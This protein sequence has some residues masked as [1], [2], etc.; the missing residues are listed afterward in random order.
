MM[1]HFLTKYSLAL[2]GA[3][4]IFLALTLFTLFIIALYSKNYLSN[5]TGKYRYW[6]LSS[7]FS[8][9]MII[10]CLAK[11][12]ETFFVGWEIV[13]LASFFLIGFYQTHARSLE[14]SLIAL[15]NYKICDVF[16]VLAI[17][18]MELNQ[19]VWAGACLIISTLAKSAQFPFSSWLYRALEGPT[20]SSTVFYGGLSLHLGPFLLIQ[21]SHLWDQS[22]ELRLLM[23]GLGLISAIYGFLVG[24]TRSD[25][26]TS[27]AF[28]SISQVGLIYMELALGWYQF[29]LWHIVGHNILRT[30]N[31]LR[32]TSFFDDF[33][34]E[35]HRSTS[36]LSLIFFKMLPDKLY[37]HALNGFY[38][39]RLFIALRNACLFFFLG[40]SFVFAAKHLW[41][42]TFHTD[43]LLL[44]IGTFLAVI[45]FV[46]PH[47]KLI[48]QSLSLIASQI[49]LLTSIFLFYIDFL[50]KVYILSSLIFLGGTLWALAPALKQWAKEK[51]HSGDPFT[52]PSQLTPL[53]HIIYLFC[54][55]S[56][57][58]SPGSIQ[59]FLQE[60]LFD[61]LWN[62]SHTFMILAL[63]GFTLNSFHFFKIGQQAF[64][65]EIFQPSLKNTLNKI[66]L[67][68][69]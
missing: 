44:L 30:W 17:F 55:I 27:F 57:T 66:K 62:K 67:V 49:L 9:G 60:A 34:K 65:Q 64:I 58:A 10:A 4:P 33:F 41:Q 53:R 47:A 14:N 61:D 68:V 23:G 36:K 51:T 37:F 31:Y 20:P 21:N 50:E 40:L 48:Y 24:S 26:K 7:F 6:L 69:G 28:A 1:Q 59:F 18:L 35:Q 43:F 38:M 29:A 52:H 56:L 63:M 2:Y 25:M 22:L 46:R 11:N 42:Q 3:G 16:F 54:V 45:A 8:I 39:D 15:A 13:G 32:S 5:E 19:H 12:L